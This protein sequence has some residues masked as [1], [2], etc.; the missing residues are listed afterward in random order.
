M[1]EFRRL[2]G[3]LLAAAMVFSLA[4][5]GGS[6]SQTE[7]SGNT[8]AATEQ[9]ATESQ[10]ATEEES[11]APA[12]V[13]TDASIAV[14]STAQQFLGHFDVSQYFSTECSTAAAYLLY[15]Q[16]FSIDSD[17]VWYSDILADYHWS[18]DTENLLVLT[19]KDNIYFSN[20]DQ[21]TAEDVLFS[22]QRFAQSPRGATNFTVVDFDASTI[23]DDG[24]TLNLQYNQEYGPWQSGLNVFVMDKSFV[25]ALPEDTDWFSADS[26][27]GSGPYSVKESVIGISIT[28]E[29]RDDWWMQDEAG[30][31]ASVQEIT[32]Y[33][34]SDSTT[35]MADYTN[36]VIDVAINLTAS[37][38]EDIAA[39]PSLGTYVAVS[40]NASAVIVLSPEN[41]ILQNEDIRKA[42]CLGT[43]ADSIGEMAWG[44]LGTP[45][46]STLNEANPYYVGGHSY[47]Y[48]PETAKE[49][50]ANSGIENPTL[51]FITNQD[52]KATTIAEAFQYCMEQ[53]GITVDFQPYDQS[54]A[55]ADYW[56]QSGGTDLLINAASIATA[57]NEA[58]DVYTFYRESFSYPCTRQTDPEIVALL[59]AGRN[60]TDEAERAQIYSDIQDW[61]YDNYSMIPICQWSTAYTYNTRIGTC[62]IPIT[63]SPSLR[64][65]TVVG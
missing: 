40:S 39:D 16:L 57:S 26:V 31:T 41:E 22:M 36:G 7:E 10:A 15:D 54:T 24:L 6:S 53:I 56:T 64:N 1:K 55:V 9:T 12:A 43:D 21:M 4:A 44:I 50:V 58:A 23:S 13:V 3:V 42:I 29:K 2:V 35:M 5:C 38:C 33:G 17:G 49:L 37:D 65:I 19:L 18:E 14:G 47:E 25:E 48:D 59:E 27:C 32:I 8:S 46:T 20:G 28:F 62:D 45:S 51:T 30:D 11:E 63:G 61:F 34:Y 60:T 52:S